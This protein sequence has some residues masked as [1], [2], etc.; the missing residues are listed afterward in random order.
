MAYGDHTIA[1]KL[2]AEKATVGR[3]R[4]AGTYTRDSELGLVTFPDKSF[5][6]LRK[7]GN[8]QAFMA[9]GWNISPRSPVDR[10]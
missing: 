9:G 1:Y 10:T 7:F 8:H 6:E 5:I 4:A 2:L 3:I